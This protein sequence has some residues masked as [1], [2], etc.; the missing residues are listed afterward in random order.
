MAML[1]VSAANCGTFMPSVVVV[2][3]ASFCALILRDV[4]ESE[5]FDEI[6]RGKKVT[7]LPTLIWRASQ[8]LRPEIALK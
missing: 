3:G 7:T 2:G 6:L 5:M 8:N 4:K 1:V